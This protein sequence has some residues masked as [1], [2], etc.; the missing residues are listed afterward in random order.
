MKELPSGFVPVGSSGYGITLYKEPPVTI[1]NSGK[2]S[3]PKKSA[4]TCTITSASISPTQEQANTVQ[5]NPT[6]MNALQ[7]KAYTKML[8]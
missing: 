3:L 5:V 2:V 1:Q 7:E 4:P 8:Q 6:V